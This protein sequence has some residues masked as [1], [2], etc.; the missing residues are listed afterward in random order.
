MKCKHV[1]RVYR[2][3]IVGE[4]RADNA[5]L[6]AQMFTDS[7]TWQIQLSDT[8]LCQSGQAAKIHLNEVRSSG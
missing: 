5:A 4:E 8:K 1:A 3:F 2:S 6:S 7:V